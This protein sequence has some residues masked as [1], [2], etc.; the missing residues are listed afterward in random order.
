MGFKILLFLLLTISFSFFWLSSEEIVFTFVEIVSL[1]LLT[2]EKNL[3]PDNLICFEFEDTELSFLLDISIV[4]T[5]LDGISF[6]LGVFKFLV[7]FA[8]DMFFILLCSFFLFKS[9]L[10]NLS[11]FFISDLPLFVCL[12][13]FLFF[14]MDVSFLEKKDFFL[15]CSDLFSVFSLFNLDILDILF[16]VTFF[17]KIFS[18]FLLFSSLF[19]F[20]NHLLMS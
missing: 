6:F 16:S 5:F 13:S 14:V 8:K 3:S 18:F 19:Y 10:L 7:L 9:F 2:L 17:F 4:F 11:L 20:V 12:T 15:F 1:L